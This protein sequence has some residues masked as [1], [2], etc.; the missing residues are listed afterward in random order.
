MVSNLPKRSGKSRKIAFQNYQPICVWC[1]VS[2]P[3]LLEVAH[4]DHNRSND[5]PK[6]LVFLCLTHHRMLDLGFIPH[7]VVAQLRDRPFKADWSILIKGGKGKKPSR[8]LSEQKKLAAFTKSVKPKRP[9]QQKNMSQIQ[10]DPEIEKTIIKLRNAA[11]KA[12]ATRRAKNPSKF[13]KPTKKDLILLQEIEKEK[14][15]IRPKNQQSKKFKI[16]RKL[17]AYKAQL[18]R[19]KQDPKKYGEVT[20]RLVENIKSLEQKLKQ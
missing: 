12:W 10:T 14:K 1:G 2:L 3:D 16:I 4:L 9:S 11:L 13:G 20:N 7:D 8:S 18:T 15:K 19:R 5:D 6:N 17:A